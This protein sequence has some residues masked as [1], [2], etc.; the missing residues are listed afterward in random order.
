MGIELYTNRGMGT[1]EGMLS[2]SGVEI[3]HGNKSTN[4][5]MGTR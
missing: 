3:G 1:G 2:L 4:R 5:G